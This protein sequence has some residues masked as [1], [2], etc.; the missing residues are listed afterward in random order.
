MSSSE[1]I[2]E[3]RN[4]VNLDKMTRAAKDKLES[5]SKVMKNKN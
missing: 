3:A 2:V 1:R 4:E 5:M